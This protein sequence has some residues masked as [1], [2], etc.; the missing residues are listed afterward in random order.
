[1]KLKTV[2]PALVILIGVFGLSMAM[3]K[4]IVPEAVKTAFTAK[5]P[6]A[7]KVKWEEEDEGEYEA[8][9]KL[10]GKE[11]SANFKADGTWLETETEIKKSALPAAVKTAIASQFAGFEIDEAEQLE[12]PDLGMAYEVSLENKKEKKE[13]QLVFSA[14]GTVLKNK[15]DDDDE[16][17]DDDDDKDGDHDTDDDDN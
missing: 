8:E 13:I 6:T 4:T 10:N 17:D 11:M 12:T 9:F 15:M 2:I 3:N 5:Y 1:M 16:V 14:D 7:K